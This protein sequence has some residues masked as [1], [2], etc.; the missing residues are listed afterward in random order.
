MS[1]APTPVTV[2]SGAA[3]GVG[4]G[5]LDV[6]LS[7]GHRVVA[8]DANAEQLTQLAEQRTEHRDRLLT[9]H[10]SVT[11]EEDWQDLLRQT[12]E[13]F[14][15]SPTG[16]VNNAGISPKHRGKRL[17]GTETPLDEW[18]AVLNVNL[19][20][21]FLGIKVLAPAMTV[22]RYGR[23]V[24]ISSVASRFGGKMGGIHYAASKTGLLGLTR[25]FAH[26]LASDGVTV[27]AVALG[28]VDAG[29]AGQVDAASN[30]EY[31]KLIPMGRFA[32][33]TDVSHAVTFLIDE[34]ASFITGMTLD[35]NGGQHMQ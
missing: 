9:V 35:V 7:T 25:A 22:A 5:I 20:G 21:A 15:H 26:E 24:N 10:A 17:P 29:M 19:T 8:M 13:T 18:N 28:R 3:G 31:M 23:I 1:A 2:V 33:I 30:A 32:N 6:L 16:L 11:S 12:Q 27:N 4:R 34:D 14:G